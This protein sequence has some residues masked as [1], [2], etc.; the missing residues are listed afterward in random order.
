MKNL[1]LPAVVA[2]LILL[3][4]CT[5]KTGAKVTA[6]PIPPTQPETWDTLGKPVLGENMDE[7]E[8][9]PVEY[10]LL[11]EIAIDA[12]S[13]QSEKPDSLLPYRAS[14]TREI[15]LLH[16]RLELSFDWT[17]KHVIGKATISLRPYFYPISSVTLEAKNFDIA[18]VAFAGKENAPLKY[19]YDTSKIVIDLGRKYARTEDIKLVIHY[20]AKPDERESFGGSAAITSDKGLFFINPDGSE[21]G[22][23]RQ[24]WTQGETENN[25]FWFPTVDKPNERCTGEI[26]LTVEDKY[27]TLSNGILTSSKKNA[28]GTRTDT[29][30]MD[31]P[32]APYLFM[33]A[34]GEFAVVKEKW[35]NIDL[36]Y[37]VD[38]QYEQDAKAIFNYTG[39]MLEFFSKKLGYDYPWSK[40]GQIIVRDFVS[41]AMENTTAVTFSEVYQKTKRELLD[42]HLSNEKVVA[43][44]MMHHWFGDLVTTENWA[45]L[46]LNEGFANYSEYLW[47][48]N[49]YGAAEADHHLFYEQQGYLFSAMGGGHPLIH[50]RY[51]NREDMFDSHSYN[52]GGSIL[53]MLRKEVGD[54]AFFAALNLY[55]KKNEY[56]DVEAHELR[57]AFEEVTGRDLNWFFNQ[58]FFSAGHPNLTISYAWNEA[59][60]QSTVTIEQS[61]NSSNEVPHV[62]QLPLIVDIYDASGKVRREAIEVTRRLQ[63]FTFESPSKPAVINVDA[64]RAL[65]A[66]V[67]D[68]HTPEEWAFLFRHSSNFR[69]RWEAI[70]NLENDSTETGRDIFKEAISD[71]FWAIRLRGISRADLK[72]PFTLERLSQLAASEPEPQVRAAA[73]ALLGE[74]GD[75]KY[76]PLA[77]KGLEG[78]QAY[79]IVGASLSTLQKLDPENAAKRAKSLES[80]SSEIIAVALSELY[81]QQ[82]DRAYLA[83]FQKHFSKIDYS[84]AFS[85]FEAYRNYLITIGDNSLIDQS[86]ASFKAVGLDGKQSQWRR[87]AATKVLADFRVYFREMNN[88]A[89][90]EEYQAM[91]DEIKAKETDE[92][93]K[94]YYDMF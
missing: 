91:L 86:A 94:M 41:G 1:L 58:W 15:D 45:N 37:Y 30:K 8:E 46:T 56:T 21:P 48:E 55:L 83:F 62:F 19:Q 61:Q 16:T 7:G 82:K 36:L 88:A 78:Q 3:N 47:L 77:E 84:P 51:D 54:E 80:D 87:F 28:N 33:V 22:K 85:F 39:E 66:V 38:P 72:D 79:S 63:T 49:K 42:D 32:H 69:D 2:A 68:R 17:K 13:G 29:W 12:Q 50:F 24:I 71:K 53:H 35:R 4:S 81:S 5:P 11:D 6:I 74:T 59:A 67:E 43:H 64:D 34:V 10:N 90:A 93:L 25:S 52:K 31:K 75:V 89:K 26:V 27:K 73:I 44:E 18:S 23:P 76:L 20:T 57:L 70:G 92:T 9:E 14:H 40:Y 65:L 60:K